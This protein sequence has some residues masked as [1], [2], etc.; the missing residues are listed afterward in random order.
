[1]IA[2][3][4]LTAP[5]TVHRCNSPLGAVQA[6][7]KFHNGIPSTRLSSAASTLEHLSN[8]FHWSG[9]FANPPLVLML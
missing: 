2:S 3:Q 9:H 1:M 4:T 6:S 7:T 5:L 8:Y